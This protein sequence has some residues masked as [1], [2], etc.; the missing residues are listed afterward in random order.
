MTVAGPFSCS[1]FVVTA[2]FVIRV[3]SV[4]NMGWLPTISR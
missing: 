3:G 1:H 4:N 2:R